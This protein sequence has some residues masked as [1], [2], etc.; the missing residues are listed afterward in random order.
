MIRKARIIRA[1]YR[2]RF[3]LNLFIHISSLRNLHNDL[4]L[5]QKNQ[6]DKSP[7]VSLVFNE[8]LSIEYITNI[9]NQS[10]RCIAQNKRAFDQQ[11]FNNKNMSL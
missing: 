11:T 10:C 2:L 9:A 1:I 7:R 5:I 3:Y 8:S 4:A 6:P